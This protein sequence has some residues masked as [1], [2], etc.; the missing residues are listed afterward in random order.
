MTDWQRVDN[1]REFLA[2][3]GNRRVR[4]HAWKPLK[5]MPWPVCNQ[6]GLLRLKNEATRRAVNAK[7]VTWE[8]A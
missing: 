7:C 2:H 3:K 6:C 1:V 5:R 4:E 8:D